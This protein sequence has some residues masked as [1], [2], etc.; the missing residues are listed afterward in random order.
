MTDENRDYPPT[1]DQATIAAVIVTWNKRVEV[2]RC[3]ESVLASTHPIQ[4]IIVVDNA[5]NDGTVE[6]IKREFG[7][8]VH[9]IVNTSNKGGSGGFYDGISAAL[10]YQTDYLWLLDNDVILSP[11]T[12]SQLLLVAQT[13]PH[14]GIVGS[15]VYFAQA[16]Q[17]IWSMGARVNS[18]L[19]QISVIGDKVRD[20]GQYNQLVEVDYVPMC[21]MLLATRVVEK[22]GSIDP[23]Y[24]VYGD[25]ADF[26][27]RARRAGFRVLSA[28]ASIA[29]HDVTLSSQRMSPLAMYYYTRNCIHY[30]FKF[31]PAWYKPVTAVLS[32]LFLSRRLLATIKYWPGLAM[33]VWVG[34]AALIGFFDAWRGKRGKVY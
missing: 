8:T 34:Q 10:C 28:P 15:K 23:D 19:A 24:F 26:C 5:S 4:A 1:A 16:P 2:L 11:Q 6:A 12:L 32:L 33:F 25:D 21:S 29:W 22:I 30:F 7:D 3:I 18:W 31:A 13:Q 14:V 27:T 17:I 9:L 20:E